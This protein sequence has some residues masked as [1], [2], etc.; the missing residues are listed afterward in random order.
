MN[1]VINTGDF[2]ESLKNKINEISP[3]YYEEAS[4]EA[5]FPYIIISGLH[6]TELKTGDLVLFDL[7][8]FADEKNLDATEELELLCDK[9]RNEL[10]DEIIC[11]VKSF[12][13]HLQFQSQMPVIEA[14]HD[15]CHR[16]ISMSARIFYS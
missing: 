4:K 13:G 16:K 11:N 5:S 14:E 7:D 1:N 12:Y 10:S 3:T 9:I 6:I 2:I 8:I 15:L